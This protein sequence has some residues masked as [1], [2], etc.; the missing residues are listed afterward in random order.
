MLVGQS[1]VKQCVRSGVS[2]RTSCTS[3]TGPVVNPHDEKRMAL[4]SS[5]GC[6]AL[7]RVIAGIY[8]LAHLFCAR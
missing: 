3:F 8:F 1:P 6:A 4:G 2:L 5:S 7:V